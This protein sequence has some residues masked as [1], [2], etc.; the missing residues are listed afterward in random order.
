MGGRLLPHGITGLSRPRVAR[1][2]A[3]PP[4]MAASYSVVWPCPSSW[5]RFPVE[6]RLAFCFFDDDEE[7]CC[8][9]SRPRFRVEASAPL[10]SLPQTRTAGPQGDCFTSRAAARLISVRSGRVGGSGLCTP[11]APLAVVFLLDCGPPCGRECCP[12][13]GFDLRFSGGSW[14]PV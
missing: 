6:G 3:S 2:S 12:S 8:K 7:C 4:S 9:H 10:V 1:V 5:V 13:V 11:P 14:C